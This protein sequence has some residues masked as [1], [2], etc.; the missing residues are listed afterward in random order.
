MGSSDLV[1]IGS[2]I[3][4]IFISALFSGSEIALLT[5]NRLKLNNLIE[6]GSEKAK[7]ILHLVENSNWLITGILIGNNV[8][9]ILATR[10]QQALQ[11]N[12]FLTILLL[13]HGCFNFG[14]CYF[15]RNVSQD[16]KQCKIL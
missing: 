13:L 1:Y 11:L 6:E 8:V 9:N 2:I 3:V 10:W 15:C 5:V 12:Y 14:Y 16:G 7:K 4:L